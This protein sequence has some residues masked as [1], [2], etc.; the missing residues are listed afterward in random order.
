MYRKEKT[1]TMK[2]TFSLIT[3]TLLIALIVTGCAPDGKLER[4]SPGESQAGETSA[5]QTVD[6]TYTLE[7]GSGPDGLAFIGAGGDIDGVVNP[8]LV[9]NP[10]DIVSIQLINADGMQH[11]LTLEDL[12][13]T[14]GELRQ[15]NA[16]ASVTFT[17][18]ESGTHVYFCSIPGHRQ[19]GMEGTLQVSASS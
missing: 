7:T 18:P 3:L 17:V 19:A 10:G 11:D 4:T 13:V 1:L 5:G 14:T 8:T 6:I 15:K 12:G 2:T 16:S 9:A